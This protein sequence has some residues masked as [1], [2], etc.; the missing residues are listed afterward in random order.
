M[1]DYQKYKYFCVRLNFKY[2]KCGW[3]AISDGKIQRS[4]KFGRCDC[5]T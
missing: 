1:D 3:Y 4:K 2:I 5:R